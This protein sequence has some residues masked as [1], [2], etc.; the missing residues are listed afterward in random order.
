M[1]EVTKTP[2]PAADVKWPRRIRGTMSV[3]EDDVM[4]FRP[5]QSG[6]PQQELLRKTADSKL[7][8]TTG[9]KQ[10]RIVAHLSTDAASPDPVD[11]LRRQ[12][13]RLAPALPSAKP[14]AKE[15]GRV[16]HHDDSLDVRLNQTQRRL[17]ITMTI[18]LNQKPLAEREL[19]NLMQQTN[20]CLAINRTFLVPQ[21]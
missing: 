10:P 3:A 14:P 8:R 4:E 1:E 13:E 2:Q 12:L 16:L 9:K 20:Q 6:D 17:T 18:D 19:I 15:R 7:Y 11:D 5:Q 21:K